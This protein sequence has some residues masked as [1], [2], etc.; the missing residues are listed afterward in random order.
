VDTGYEIRIDEEARG[1]TRIGEGDG[2]PFN[3]TG[4]IYKMPIGNGV[5]QQKYTNTQRLAASL[6]KPARLR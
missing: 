4:A 5:G 2:F 6:C 3:R 1:D